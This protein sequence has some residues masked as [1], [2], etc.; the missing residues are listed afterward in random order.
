MGLVARF[1]VFVEIVGTLGI[2]IILALHGFN[3]GLGFLFSTENV[4]NAASNPLGLD[5]GGELADRCLSDRSPRSR[6]H[7]LRIRVGR[8]H[9]RGDR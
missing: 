4:Q 5:F 1:G 8:R 3:H 6:L 7:L 2:A 9:L